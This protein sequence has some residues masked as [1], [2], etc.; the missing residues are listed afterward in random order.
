MVTTTNR[1]VAFKPPV[2]FFN[3]IGT[4]FLRKFIVNNILL[5]HILLNS[6]TKARATLRYFNSTQTTER[7]K[8]TKSI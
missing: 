7:F 4:Y 5:T 3:D 8:P 1:V 2:I 6:Y